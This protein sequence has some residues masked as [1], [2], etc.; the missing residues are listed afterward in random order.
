MSS[1][2]PPVTTGTAPPTQAP[3]TAS[4]SAPPPEVA[5]LSIGAKLEATI[6]STLSGKGLVDIETVLG[7]LQLQ[8]TFPLPKDGPLQL[9]LIGKG[10]QLQFLISAIGGKPPLLAGRVAGAG[11][12][13]PGTN[14]APSAGTAGTPGGTGAVMGDVAPVKL[15]IGSETTA[16]LLRASMAPTPA[17]GQSATSPTAPLPGTGNPSGI[18]GTQSSAG[19]PGT[20]ISGKPATTAT[21]VSPTHGSGG[22]GGSAQPSSQ[23]QAQQPGAPLPAGTRFNVR[24]T[25]VIPANQLASGGGIPN[26]GGTFLSPGQSITGVV[27][28]QNGSHQPIVQTH[29]GPISINTPSPVPTGTTLTFQLVSMVPEARNTSQH[30]MIGRAGSIIMETREWQAL[31]DAVKLLRDNNP[32]VAGQILNAA[33]PRLDTTLAANIL[34]FIAAL[35]GAEIRNWFGDAPVRAL[36]RLRP[37]LLTRL[38]DDFSQISKLSDD[39]SGD[40]RSI[41]V[42]LINGSEIEQ[43]HLFLRRNATDEEDE[44]GVSETRFV[45]DVDL[46]RIGRFQMDG[47]IVLEKKKFDL[48]IRTDDNLTGKIQNDIREIFI[49]ATEM[50]G[51]TGGLTYRA[52][53][54]DFIDISPDSADADDLGLIV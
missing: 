50:A 19:I 4:V 14:M 20:A 52:A 3:P 24:I 44:D 13:M 1:V 37:D 22:S 27:V 39:T 41:P 42:P 23:V 10:S 36:Q 12:T 2:A 32:A 46:S 31:D 16:T 5:N 30:A 48:I 9:Q 26:T 34:F 15:T 43:I 17:T 28:G 51:M 7:K 11:T 29:A 53:P 40:W 21:G 8:T 6:L 25:G 45:I 49:N 38:G 35:R 18:P 33:M 47:L 54:P